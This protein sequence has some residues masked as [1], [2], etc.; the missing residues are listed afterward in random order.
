MSTMA[1]AYIT[2]RGLA[3]AIRF[4]CL[5]LPSPG[6]GEVLVRVTA[7]AANHVD[8]FIRSGAFPVELPFPFVV[9]RDLVG[10]V[11]ESEVEG[12]APGTPVWANSL[13]YQGR[14]GSFAQYAVVPAE[15]LYPLP[16]GADPVAAVSVLHTGTTAYLGLHRE[17]RLAEGEV[18][19]VAGAGG[20]VGSAVAQLA[21]AAG[22]RVIAVDR[23]DNAGW[24]RACG[25]DAVLDRDGDWVRELGGSAPSGVDVFWDC[26]GRNDLATTVPLMARGGR[27]ILSAGL[28]SRAVLPVGECYTRDVS[29]RGFAVTNAS[30]PEL[31]D[32]ARLINRQLA[33][34][35]LRGRIRDCLPLS[36]AAR[37]H[38]MLEDG[39]APG[40]VVLVPS[41]KP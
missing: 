22:A 14:Q 31:A 38:R 15:R 8:T 21:T 18:I 34:G 24:C 36:E 4:G 19:T 39:G 5:P 16:A 12:W 40:R 13:G 37:A 41:A 30:V 35:G 10:V 32:A 11:E 27:I 1:A 3:G 6:P 26:S 2:E 7:V 28:T 9:G 17:A 25:A 33:S 23:R 29:L 20:G